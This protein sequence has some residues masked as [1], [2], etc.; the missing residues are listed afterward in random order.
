MTTH[1]KM[2]SDYLWVREHSDADSW[3]RARTHGYN[4]LYYHVPNRLERIEM[5]HRSIGKQTDWELEKFRASKKYPDRG[6]KKRFIKNVFRFFKHPIGY[7]FWKTYQFR[8]ARQR[9]LAHTL[10]MAAICSLIYLKKVSL[11]Q[12]R[13]NY[14]I[15]VNGQNV[16]G[17]GLTKFGWEDESL[18]RQPNTIH[19][20]LYYDLS[21]HKIVSNPARV[22]NYRKYFEMRKKHGI[23]NKPESV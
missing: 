22:Q 16:Q 15:Q 14:Y 8:S 3:A 23:T 18:G 7:L 10:G 19:S 1:D 2:N 5:I 21:G 6:N 4:Y 11:A 13:K 17:A 20:W 12:A 9:A